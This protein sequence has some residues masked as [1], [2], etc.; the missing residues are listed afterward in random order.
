MIA[1]I[2]RT[3]RPLRPVRGTGP[4]SGTNP[5]LKMKDHRVQRNI[6]DQT[7]IDRTGR[8]MRGL[9]LDF[10]PGLVQVDLL[11][12]ERQR[13][14]AGA[15]RHDLHTQRTRVEIACPVDVPD[16]QHE[17]VQ[18]ADM[19]RT[20]SNPHHDEASSDSGRRSGKCRVARRAI[21]SGDAGPSASRSA[22]FGITKRQFAS[23]RSESSVEPNN[24]RGKRANGIGSSVG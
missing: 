1:Q 22:M 15:E 16:G 24:N 20:R 11:P 14:A 17:M 3:D 9:R 10:V 18:V 12:P 6:R 4:C 8:R 7:E 21:V 2:D 13:L 19:H 5:W 23:P